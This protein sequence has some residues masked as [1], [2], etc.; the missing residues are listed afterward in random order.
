MSSELAEV[1]P[2]PLSF[3]LT[4]NNKKISLTLKN[5]TN[6]YILYKF[7]I[8]T[9]GVLLAKPPT[10]F[11]PPSKSI[12]IDVHLINNNLPLE[13][14][15]KTKLLIMF[16]QSDEEIKTV[17]QAKKKFQILKNE[18]NEKQELI[19]NID[20]IGEANEINKEEDEKIVY[21]NYAQL[22]T[23]LDEKNLE[24]KKNIEIYKKKYETLVNLENKSNKGKRKNNGNMNNFIL[25]FILLLGLIFGA[26]CACGYNKLFHKK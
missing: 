15:L 9:R 19:V 3:S 13:E 24:I 6:E 10:S 12:S 2:N 25:I 20:I 26:N 17:E 5:I 21:M 8:N 7:L 14:Y 11:I 22:K 1:F 4:D 23:E 16:I 18:E